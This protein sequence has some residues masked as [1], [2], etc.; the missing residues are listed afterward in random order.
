MARPSFERQLRGDGRKV[1]VTGGTGFIG[2][3]VVRLL[4]ARGDRVYCT[5]RASSPGLGLAGLQVKRIRLDLNDLYSVTKAL[6]GVEDV[7]HLAGI[8]DPSPKGGELMQRVHVDAARTLCDASL[9]VGVRRLL[10]CSSSVTVG[11]GSLENPGNEDTPLPDLDSFYGRETALRRYHDT[12]L[13][14]EELVASY[15]PRGLETVTVNPDFVIGPWDIKPT[16]GALIVAMA[17]RWI[18]LHPSGGKCFIDAGDC[19]QGHLLAMEKGTPGERYLLGNHNLSYADFMGLVARVVGRRPPLGPI[20]SRVN[21][22]LGRVGR[23]LHRVDA[24][25]FA[26]LDPMVLQSMSEMRYRT[27][28]KS[29]EE[30]GV[31]RTSIEDAVL[32]AYNWFKKQ[33]YV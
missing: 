3:N 32:S 6:R 22:G 16:S 8:F 15:V 31:P 9:S 24:H 14:G 12:K 5:V 26:G 33:R 29:W 1:L 21:R 10:Y 18:P 2:A 19:A 11:F 23:V 27:G 25:R 30:L 7:Y 17:K 13:A 28:Q 20:P 4:V